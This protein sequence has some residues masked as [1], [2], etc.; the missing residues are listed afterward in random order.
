MVNGYD[1]NVRFRNRHE[2]NSGCERWYAVSEQRQIQCVCFNQCIA[3][4][5]LKPRTS[6]VADKEFSE[7]GRKKFDRGGQKRKF[8][9]KNKGGTTGGGVLKNG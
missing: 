5:A 1:F 7:N 4:C 6:P 2:R 8:G 9:L 3:E